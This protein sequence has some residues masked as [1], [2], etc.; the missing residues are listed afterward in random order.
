VGK[1]LLLLCAGLFTLVCMGC[2]TAP[3]RSVCGNTEVAVQETVRFAGLDR[4]SMLH[5]RDNVPINY[6]TPY[7]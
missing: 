7:R 2:E 4:P 3:G 1:S 6:Y 5:M